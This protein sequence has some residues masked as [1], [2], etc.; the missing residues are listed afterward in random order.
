MAFGAVSADVSHILQGGGNG[1]DYPVPAVKFPEPES[2]YLPP[3][4]CPP[5]TFGQYPNCQRPQPRKLFDCWL[6]WLKK[7]PSKFDETQ[8][9]QY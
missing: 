6:A 2:N 4:E 1:Y 5:G 7:E 3:Q 9:L 8:L